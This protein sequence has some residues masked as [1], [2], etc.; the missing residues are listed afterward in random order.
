MSSSNS[1]ENTEESYSMYPKT[2]SPP[3]PPH[4][5]GG[6][7]FP[8]YQ[9]AMPIYA[10]PQTPYLYGQIPAYPFNM[11]G[12]NQMM[13][14]HGSMP[15]G[16]ESK[17][18]WS[19]SGSGISGSKVNHYQNHQHSASYHPQS[20]STNSSNSS[21]GSTFSQPK[22]QATTNNVASTKYKFYI[23]SA[24]DE[25]TNNVSIEFPL[26][27]NTSEEEFSKAK[28]AR[29]RLRVESLDN[30]FEKKETVT[31]FSPVEEKEEV[32]ETNTAEISDTLNQKP[33]GKPEAPNKAPSEPK[34][35]TTVKTSEPVSEEN[36]KK[37]IEDKH[38]STIQSAAVLPSSTETQ[39]PA[40]KSWSAIASSAI[41]KPK[42]MNH[43]PTSSTNNL[44]GQGSSQAP[45][46]KDK[47]YI[48]STTLGAEPLGSITLRMC[49]D[50]DYL[51]YTQ[52]NNESILPIGS[53]IP[54]GIVNRANICFMSSVL[55]V[56]LYCRPF[57]SVLN[58]ASTRN[59]YSKVNSNS[60]KLL[61]ACVTIYK[62]FDKQTYQ[63]E[64]EN[65]KNKDKKSN[66]KAVEEKPMNNFAPASDAINP[67][68][69][70]KILSTLP[71]FKDLQWGHQE[72]AEEFLTHLLDQLHEEFIC[73]INSLTDNEILNIVQSISDE[74]L[75]VFFVRN[76]PQY[77]KADFMK[78]AS[79]QLKSLISKYGPMSDDDD[80]TNGWHEVSSTSKKGK[81]T[82]TAA[83]RTVEIEQSPIS[84]LFGGQFR[85]V[86]DIPNNKESQSITLDP[87][88]TI[89][90]DISDSSIDDLETAFKKFS[91][92][93][94]L[95]FKSSSGSDV[96]AKKQT[97]IDKL[98]Q[99]LLVQ[100]KRFSFINNTDKDN[101][102]TNYNAYNGRIEKI[103]KKIKYDHELTI[104]LESLSPASIDTKNRAYELTGVI[105]HHG[106]SSDGG[107]YT[108]DVYH[109]ELDK[110]Y[111]IDDVNIIELEKDDVLKGGED[112]NDTRTAYILIYRKKNN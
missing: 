7:H 66:G 64:K 13:Y 89:Q 94:L 46:R 67:D 108:A 56:L 22:T 90:L 63:K 44:S 101:N 11:M 43:S 16:G 96:E 103:R 84:N 15:Q 14:Q 65:D 9:A 100:L 79:Y 3:P 74:E 36:E 35:V 78:N 111:R 49:F 50:P 102:M 57:I 88:Q 29:Y 83:K 33:V 106:L 21:T 34:H 92:Y 2:S 54:R 31:E 12:Q 76:L 91:E 86:L 70:Y 8:T 68:D 39:K 55:Q 82:K 47:K 110:W 27:F 80:E 69:F 24:N 25:K 72:D 51:N 26:F 97:F 105:Y 10:Y 42:S 73:S 48:P 87:F 23:P 17:K 52:N 41:S 4:Q 60:S 85:S 30:T 18:K 40:P 38:V 95:P 28:E 59:S 75:K 93:E 98:P 1:H 71:K 112:G 6:M 32:P 109:K 77:K 62:Q 19:N 5:G 37:V 45:Q 20:S 61:D 107:H 58:I 104:P 81:K 53:I 99:V